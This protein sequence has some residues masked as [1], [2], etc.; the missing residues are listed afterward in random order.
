MNQNGSPLKDSILEA[1]ARFI[2]ILGESNNTIPREIGPRTPLPT[3]NKLI[4][5][6]NVN[7]QNY[8]FVDF[9]YYKFVTNQT[10]FIWGTQSF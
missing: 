5:I 8:A 4:Y 6:Q 1:L 2:T 3:P 7:K 10:K 9:N